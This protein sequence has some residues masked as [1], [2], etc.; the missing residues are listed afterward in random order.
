M[1]RLA[2][3]DYSN[4]D[5]HVTKITQ[6]NYP[7]INRLAQYQLSKNVYSNIM[8]MDELNMDTNIKTKVL[9]NKLEVLHWWGRELIIY[10]MILIK[11][12]SWLK[13]QVKT[14]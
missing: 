4:R 5:N 14:S 13:Y 10:K 1:N 8:V 11:V 2:A 12:G 3:I 6:A 9:T 7:Q